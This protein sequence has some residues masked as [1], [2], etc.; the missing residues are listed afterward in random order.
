MTIAERF[1]ALRPTPVLAGAFLAFV[2]AA[3]LL[4]TEPAYS[5]VFYLAVVPCA[6]ARGRR[7]STVQDGGYAVAIALIYWSAAT[8]LWG[9]DDGHRWVRFL[10]DSIMTALFVDAMMWVLREPANRARLAGVLIWAGTANAILSIALGLLVRHDGDRLHGWGV[11][12]HP[13]LGAS[14]M[15]AAYLA[16]LVRVLTVRQWRAI[17]VA[18]LLAMAA[19]VV[20]TASR[21][22]L[23]AGTA[24]TL[25]LCAAGPWRWRALASLAGA[26]AL[27]FLLPAGLRHH[28]ESALVARGASHRFEIWHR[29]LQM[30]A[31]HP[32]LGNGLAANLDLPGMTFPHDLYLSVLFYSGAVG[33]LLFAAL[34][35]TV[36]WRLARDH[37]P[38]GQGDWLWMAALWIGALVSGLTDLGQITK[39]PGP[40]WFIFWLP[41]GLVLA[42][43]RPIGHSAQMRA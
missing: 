13:I 2:A 41:V 19:F 40:M 15:L 9:R 16:A 27:W 35:L 10:I 31:R 5:L 26:A 25:F 29:T 43:V 21:G 7:G 28:Q 42:R 4:P 6:L 37:G 30:V 22:P 3:F 18:A 17:H 12:S 33:L 24:A 8:L 32:L 36:T 39:G 23:L 20:L 14:V 1:A 34:A 11:T 38:A